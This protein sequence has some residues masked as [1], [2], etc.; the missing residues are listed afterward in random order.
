M[1]VLRFIT[2]AAISTALVV[3]CDEG[4]DPISHVPPGDDVA[5]PTVTISY[6]GEGTLIRVKED[7]APVNIEFQVEDDIEIGTITLTMDG[8]KIGEVSEFKDYRRD[9]QSFTYDNVT[10]GQ[11]TLVRSEER[12]VGRE[13]RSRRAA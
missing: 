9:I 10:K 1:K 2:F 7:V 3:G 11:H 12:R 8:T 4:I 6:P 13:S 5:A